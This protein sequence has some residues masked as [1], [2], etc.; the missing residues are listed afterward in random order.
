[1]PTKG[2]LKSVALSSLVQNVIALPYEGNRIRK[3]RRITQSRPL[4]ISIG[5]WGGEGAG[6]KGPLAAWRAEHGVGI[7]G[8]GARS[9]TFFKGAWT[10]DCWRG[11]RGVGLPVGRYGRKLVLLG[12]RPS[13]GSSGTSGLEGGGHIEWAK[14]YPGCTSLK[15]RG[16]A[17]RKA[18]ERKHKST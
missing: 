9:W 4:A 8:R 1:M 13:R 10:R 15:Y 11:R 2:A 16:R 5:G 6:Q 12:A 18:V 3:K 17:D 14:M 7:R